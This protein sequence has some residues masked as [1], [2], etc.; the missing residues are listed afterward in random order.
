[1][2]NGDEEHGALHGTI[3]TDTLPAATSSLES[4]E[5]VDAFLFFFQIL[6]TNLELVAYMQESAKADKYVRV[7]GCDVLAELRGL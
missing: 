7:D 1:M 5:F 4:S 6:E 2:E 3:S